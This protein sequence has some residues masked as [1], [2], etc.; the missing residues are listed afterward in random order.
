MEGKSSL[1]YVYIGAV[2]RV[3]AFLFPCNAPHTPPFVA[4]SPR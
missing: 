3:K 4:A 2:G 1:V